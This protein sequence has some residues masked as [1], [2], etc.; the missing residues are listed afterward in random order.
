MRI[1]KISLVLMVMAIAVGTVSAQSGGLVVRVV[2]AQGS[3]PGAIVTLS[4]DKA[5]VKTTSAVTDTDGMVRFPVLRAGTGYAIEVSAPTYG[6]VRQDGIHVSINETVT[7]VVQLNPALVETVNVVA[8]KDTIDLEKS[9]VSSKFSDDFIQD[10]PVPGR[11]YQNVLTLAP[12]V[13]DANGDGNPNVHGSRSRDF[14]AMVSGVSNVD[15]LTGKQMNQVNPN[16]I[17]EMEVITAG[18]GVEFGRAQGGFANIIQKQGSNEFEGLVEMLY[19]SDKLD[20]NPGSTEGSGARQAHYTIWRPSVQFSGPLVKDK[21]WYRL[22]HEY[23]QQEVPVD[24]TSSVEIVKTTRKLNSDQLTWQASPRNKLAL[25]YQNDP[26]EIVNAGV[27]SIL[28]PESSNTIEFGGSTTSL[29][30]TAPY[31]PKL[32]VD[33]TIAYQDTELKI[34][35]SQTGVPNDCYPNDVRDP[36]LPLI[37]A[38]CFDLVNTRFSGASNFNHADHR[39]RLTMNAKATVYGGRFWGMSHQF[40][41]GMSIENERYFRDQTVGPQLFKLFEESGFQARGGDTGNSGGSAGGGGGTV[42]EEGGGE[43]EEEDPG[44]KALSRQVIL[45]RV[46]VPSQ[47][48]STATGTTWGFYAEDQM[49][50]VQNL[51]LKIGLRLDSEALNARG[52]SLVN[53]EAEFNT[54][55]SKL[56]D[57]EQGGYIATNDDRLDL[58]IANYTARAGVTNFFEQIGQETGFGG[59]GCSGLCAP[60]F[61]LRHQQ[62]PDDLSIRNTNVSPFLSVAWDPWSNGKTKFALTVGRHY[63]NTPLNIPMVELD[64]ATADVNLFCDGFDCGP[65]SANVVPNISEVDRNLR[66]PYSDEFVLSM[67][68]E[69]FTETV[70]RLTYINRKYKDQFQDLDLNHVPGDFYINDL[71]RNGPTQVALGSDGIPDDCTGELFVPEEGEPIGGGGLGGRFPVGQRADD[72]TD[73]YVQNPFWGE[74]FLIGNFNESNYEA[75]VLEV[76][77]RQYRGWELQ[78]SYTWSKSVGNGEDFNQTLGDDRTLVDDEFGFQSQDQRHVVKVNATTITP[79]GFRLGTAI[80]WQT[81]LPYSILNQQGALDAIP[82]DL[83][84][85]GVP[86]TR[87]RTSFPTGV[88]NSGRNRAWWNVDLKFTKEMNVGNGMN[89]QTSLEIYNMLDERVYMIFNPGSEIGR[90]V[91]GRNEAIITNGRRFLLSGKLTF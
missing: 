80:S 91:N 72:I 65:G 66:T 85:L 15:P 7:R 71:C 25:Q 76:N 51:T 14:K 49:K 9:D 61:S 84:N 56:A 17:E 29:T 40:K 67:E 33:T 34:R 42:P 52:R 23:V 74:V 64:A 57:L 21:L 22:S 37:N 4:N 47:T 3:L 20:G 13:Q 6:T 58:I 69:L 78:G 63:N 48:F 53:P 27:S 16:S 1:V 82:P 46:S 60:G 68:R 43:E 50:P 10:L 28:P 18:A 90:Q 11:Y 24:V 8:E 31:S 73:L 5:Y 45:A 12:G 79:W 70:G 2:D 77:R 54:Y 62:L 89:L 35:P 75:Y 39:Q 87:A 36:N 41:F 26:L 83:G 86:A 44:L 88:R 38:S 59:L 19:Q 30:W 55:L 81:G 32:L